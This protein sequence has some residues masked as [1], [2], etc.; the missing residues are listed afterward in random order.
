MNR[1]EAINLIQEIDAECK[2]IVG[3]SFMLVKPNLNDPLAAGYQVRVKAKFEGDQALCIQVIANRLGYSVKN[4]PEKRAL[5]VFEP[6]EGKGRK[7]RP[8]LEET[9]IM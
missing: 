1:Q 7:A 3:R 8:D 6:R 4:E 9:G 2:D 5:T